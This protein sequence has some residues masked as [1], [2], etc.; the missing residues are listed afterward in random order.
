MIIYLKFVC[1]W[2]KCVCIRNDAFDFENKIHPYL[3]EG[4]INVRNM[5]PHVGIFL[6]V[7]CLQHLTFVKRRLQVETL[8]VT[9]DNN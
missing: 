7:A 5:Q 6:N 4:T 9:A 2:Y 8:E 1:V 3:V